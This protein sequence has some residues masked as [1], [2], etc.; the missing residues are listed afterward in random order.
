MCPC[1]SEIGLSRKFYIS[2][3][4]LLRYQAQFNDFK[5]QNVVGIVDLKFPIRLEG[6]LLANEQMAQ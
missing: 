1:Y 2:T 6:L 5:I 4:F 3:L